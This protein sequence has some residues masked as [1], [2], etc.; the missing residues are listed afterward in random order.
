MNVTRFGGSLIFPGL[1][2][3]ALDHGHRLRRVLLECFGRL[4]HKV[5]QETTVKGLLEGGERWR[6]KVAC[7]NATSSEGVADWTAA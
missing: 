3:M 2:E 1:V 6:N 4:A 7:A 5:R